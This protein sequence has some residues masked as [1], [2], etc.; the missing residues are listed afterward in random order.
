M[1]RA[2]LVVENHPDLRAEIIAILSRA[3]YE[4][5]G[6]STGE[7]ALL[8]IR[9]HDYRYILLDVDSDTAGS[10]LVDSCAASG[11]LKKIVLMTNVEGAEEMPGSS[12]EC[13]VL[14]KPFDKTELLSSIVR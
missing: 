8:K 2:I 7:A 9:E 10:A 6:V 13:S 3:K 11:T 1:N 12:S 14:R 5:E 4:C